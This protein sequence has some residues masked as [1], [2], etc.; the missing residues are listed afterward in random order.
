MVNKWK[1]AINWSL[2]IAVITL[3]LAAIFSIVSTYLLSGVTWAV[4]MV[5]VFII[6][7]I[8]IFFDMLG[9][10]STAADETPFHAMA[11]ERVN[12]SKQAIQIVRNADRFASFC[13]DVIGDIS[14]IISGTASAIVVISFT[15]S[16]GQTED[17]LFHYIVAVVFTS[18][19]A[20]VT[21]GGKAFGKSMAIRYSTPILFQVGRLF[22]IL[23]D[24]FNIVVLKENKK[25]KNK[26]N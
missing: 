20:A 26:R 2:A 8:G 22:Y 10:A 25:R 13:N 1:D 16:V 4:G 15:L 9:I 18:V 19:V 21:V 3:V 11:A 17:S 23:E 6:V 7:F 14:G 5:I 12:G 24:K